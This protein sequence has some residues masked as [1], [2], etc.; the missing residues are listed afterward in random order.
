MRPQRKENVD[1][2]E[3]TVGLMIELDCAGREELMSRKRKLT[4]VSWVQ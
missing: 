2:C 4:V 1:V 3:V